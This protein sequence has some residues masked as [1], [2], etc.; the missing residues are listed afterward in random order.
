MNHDQVQAYG[1]WWLVFVNSTIFIFFAFSFTHPKTKQDWR[2]FGAFSGFVLALFAEMYGFPLTI[3]FL[4]GWIARHYPGTDPLSHDSGH[5]WH[6][7]LGLRG[8][9]HFDVLHVLSIVLVTGGFYLLASSWK[10]LFQAQR[11][12]SLATSGPYRYVRHPQYDAFVLIMF[13]F[14]LLWPTLLTLLMF[15]VLLWMYVRLAKREEAEVARAF[16]DTYFKYAEHTPRF[17]PDWGLKAWQ[18]KEN[19]RQFPGKKAPSSYA[20]FK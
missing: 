14:L 7:L 1:L 19:V 5:L 16:G 18:P 9:P 17:I 3:Y 11:E 13:G 2:S 12:K 20:K 4:S 8:N 6:T 10:V 15:P